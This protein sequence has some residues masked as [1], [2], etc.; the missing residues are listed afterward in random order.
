MFDME[1]SNF[2]AGLF[3]DLRDDRL[4]AVKAL[5]EVQYSVSVY[6]DAEVAEEAVVEVHDDIEFAHWEEKWACEPGWTDGEEMH[7]IVECASYDAAF[8]SDAANAWA[9]AE[10]NNK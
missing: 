8:L 10:H 3:E 7:D 4:E 2:F 6:T 5:A 9:V 1:L